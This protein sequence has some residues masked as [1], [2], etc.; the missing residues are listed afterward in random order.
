M[1][2]HPRKQRPRHP[3][4]AVG[5]TLPTPILQLRRSSTPAEVIAHAAAK[6]QQAGKTAAQATTP[7]ATADDS[8]VGRVPPG[9]VAALP[10]RQHVPPLIRAGQFQ[11]QALT[12]RA[13][14]GGGGDG[15]CVGAGGRRGAREREFFGYH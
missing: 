12:A 5:D 13:G 10:A 14:Q 4:H 3:P 6:V 8:T 1:G 2:R 7:T 11:Q 15:E 9:C